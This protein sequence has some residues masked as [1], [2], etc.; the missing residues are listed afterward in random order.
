MPYAY[1]TTNKKSKKE[2]I[3]EITLE[4]IETKEE[5]GNRK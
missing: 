2:L 5:L 1:K 4:T 3:K